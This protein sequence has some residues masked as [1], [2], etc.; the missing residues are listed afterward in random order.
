MLFHVW[1]STKKRKWLLQGDIATRAKELLGSTATEKGIRL[2]EHETMIDHVHMLLDVANDSE[3]SQAMKLIK[4]RSAYELLREF[5]EVKLAGVSSFWQR[6]FRAR[7]VP[8]SQEDIVRQYI[9]TQDQRLEKY[10]R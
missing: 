3:L 8:D 5:P 7:V 6:S 1:F 9:R 2:I 10:E 4:G